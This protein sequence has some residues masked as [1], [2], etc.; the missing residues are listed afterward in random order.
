MDNCAFHVLVQPNFRRYYFTSCPIKLKLTSI[1]GMFQI[2]ESC[3]FLKKIE[4][5]RISNSSENHG[6]LSTCSWGASVS[7]L[8]A[9]NDFKCQMCQS[10]Y[11]VKGYLRVRLVTNL[12][13]VSC[14]SATQFSAILFILLARSSSNSPRSFQRFRR[15]LR[16]NFHW[17]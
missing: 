13:C 3:L 12:Q 6:M 10:L 11:V 1:I 9:L 17:I 7:N 14:P 15:T 2:K 16:R 4:M 5:I 8:H